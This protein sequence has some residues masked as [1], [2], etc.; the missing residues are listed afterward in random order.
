M[1]DE[2]KNQGTGD[3][4]LG[5]GQES[6]TAAKAYKL[7]SSAEQPKASF[8]ENL[9][10]EKTDPD[11]KP[12]QTG[13]VFTK[14]FGGAKTEAPPQPL[15]PTT[16]APSIASLL[17][18]R[19]VFSERD[20][21]AVE[22]QNKK[23]AKTVLYVSI[24]L[25]VVVYAF[26]YTRLDPNF[27]WFSGSLGQNPAQKF[28]QSNSK[29]QQVKTN[30][31]LDNYRMLRLLLDEI[32]MQID[33]YKRQAFIF[34]SAFS[35]KSE[36]NAASAQL[37]T[38]KDGIKQN[39]TQVQAILNQPLKIDTYLPSPVSPEEREKFFESL[40]KD[41]L[42]RQKAALSSGATADQEEARVFDNIVRLVDNRGFRDFLK[43]QD[44]AQISKDE[45]RKNFEDM[46]SRIREEGANDFVAVNNIAAKRINWAQVI[47]NVHDVT[48]TVDA[49]YGGEG[50]FK[51]AGG[52]LFNSYQFDSKTN[53]VSISG[54]TKT[55]NSKTF[56]FIANLVD[57]IEKSDKF[58]EI[59]FRSFTKSRDEGGDFTSSLNLDFALQQ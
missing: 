15:G 58:K 3:R 30:I 24:A 37:K 4:V 55:P 23:I 49:T 19:P 1:A 34:D 28:E 40:L 59:D 2:I 26:F 7:D 6:S 27:T 12:A 18:P 56:S 21:E 47:N 33:S 50:L 35:T 43:T 32:N 54:I 53:R 52:F 14:L 29:L 16:A 10:K 51:V 9:V 20:M 5:T 48:R 42:T 41:E 31:N 25:T 39:L 11:A 13:N 44:L 8:L 57:A 46:L 17:G 38:V 36:K 22:T 45:N